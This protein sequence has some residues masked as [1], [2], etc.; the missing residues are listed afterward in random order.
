MNRIFFAKTIFLWY[1]ALCAS[2][3]PVFATSL[4]NYI[5]TWSVID[6][7]WILDEK[8]EEYL[9]WEITNIYNNTTAEIAI[10]TK[11][12][13]NWRDPFDVSL[14]LA[15]YRTDDQD[16]IKEMKNIDGVG[17]KEINNWLLVLI[18]PNERKR[19]IQV[20]YGLEWAIPDAIARRMWEGLLVPAFRQEKYWDWLV[21]L[22][23]AFSG[24]I[25][26]EVDAWKSDVADSW[27]NVD[28]IELFIAFLFITFFFG[29]VIKPS[30]KTTKEK[31][32]GSWVWSWIFTLLWW[33]F[34]WWSALWL[35]IPLFLIWLVVLFGESTWHTWSYWWSWWFR[36]SWWSFSWFWWWSFG[37]WWAWW[38][39]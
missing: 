31:Y 36:G 17:N 39:R 7:A 2:V 5:E 33:L 14:D 28:I 20:G 26:G 25:A 37:W 34:A 27:D 3:F 8:Y 30:L 15:R 24:A 35:L 13:L 32:I 4:G 22:V 11:D 23:D 21:L 1:I 6:E 10:V 18:A 29:P 16:A 9:M 38:W 19:Q 12:S